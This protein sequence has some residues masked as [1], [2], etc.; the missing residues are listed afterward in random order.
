MNTQA[1][2]FAIVDSSQLIILYIIWKIKKR[3]KL[4]FKKLNL[5]TVLINLLSCYIAL[6][7]AFSLQI[8]FSKTN[9]KA[10]QYYFLQ[11]RGLSKQNE[12]IYR[13]IFSVCHLHYSLRLLSSLI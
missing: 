2:F 9:N 11:L 4:P 1:N 7:V 13:A 8:S 12:Q 10:E 3:E 6:S 5:Q